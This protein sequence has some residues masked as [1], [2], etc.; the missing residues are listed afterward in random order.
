MKKICVVTGTRAEYGIL[1]DLMRMIAE[2]DQLKL[3]IIVTN[4]HLS[5]EFGLTY[6]EIE[7]D[8][9]HIDKKVEM[10]LSSVSPNG[11]VKSMGVGMIGL[12]DALEELAPDLLLVLGDR[13]EILVAAEAALMYRIPVAHLYGGEITEGVWDDAIRHA[14]TKLSH[15]HFTSTEAYRQRVIQMGEQPDRVFWVGALGIDNIRREKI[16]Q[17]EELEESMGFA[18]GENSFLITFHPVTMEDNTAEIQCRELLAALEEFKEYKLLFTLA[19]SDAQGQVIN[20]LIRDFVREHPARAMSV[21]SLGKKRYYATLRYVTAVVG[22]SSSGLVEA[23]CFGKP[24]LNIGDR[25]KGR[26]RGKGVVDC[27]PVKDSIVA[28]LQKVLTPKFR[29]EAAKAANPYEK[30]DTLRTIFE[31]L[32]RVEPEKITRKSFYDWSEMK[33]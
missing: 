25:Q 24:V 23:P 22:N 15:L 9:F 1:S 12:A 14:I 17:K 29:E 26:I 32:K 16:M 2:D 18:L 5:P 6:Q 33:L 20:G 10:L 7:G 30:P 11:I 27:L 8:G 21:A 13:Y 19:N 28:G 4:M 31:I 3:Q